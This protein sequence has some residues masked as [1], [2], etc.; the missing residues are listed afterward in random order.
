MSFWDEYLLSSISFS[1]R[2]FTKSPWD[3]LSYDRD[4]INPISVIYTDINQT[5]L[6]RNWRQRSSCYMSVY[7]TSVNGT[8][9]TWCQFGYIICY[10][11]LNFQLAYCTSSICP[12]A[13]KAVYTFSIFNIAKGNNNINNNEANLKEELLDFENITL[14]NFHCC[15]LYME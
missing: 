4:E 14:N 5:K 12:A 13:S 2:Y 15:V 6:L 7:L 11:H 1:P 9:S 10:H 8:L 3:L